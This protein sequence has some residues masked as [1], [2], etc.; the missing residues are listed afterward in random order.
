MKLPD[1]V[2]GV[3]ADED[4][5]I[6]EAIELAR[7]LGADQAYHIPEEDEHGPET[8]VDSDFVINTIGFREDNVFIVDE[9]DCRFRGPHLVV[10]TNQFTPGLSTCDPNA[11]PNERSRAENHDWSGYACSYGELWHLWLQGKVVPLREETT[12]IRADT[13]EEAEV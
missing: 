10:A 13:G 8:E 5:T 4:V 1:S 6:Q 9:E 11:M 7:E 3:E 12:Y 2:D